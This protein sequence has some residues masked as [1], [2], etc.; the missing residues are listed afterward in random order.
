MMVRNNYKLK[1]MLEEE[2]DLHKVDHHG[3]PH[4]KWTG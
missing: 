3:C 2:S 4:L 1:F